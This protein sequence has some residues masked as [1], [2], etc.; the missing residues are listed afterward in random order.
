[1]VLLSPSA[2]RAGIEFSDLSLNLSERYPRAVL[3]AGGVPLVLSC[4]AQPRYLAEAVRRADGVLLTGGGDVLPSLYAPELPADLAAT[5][6]EVEPERDLAE[7]MLVREAFLQRKPLLAICRGH[8]LLNVAL[9][10]SLIVDIPRQLPQ[11]L[12]HRRVDRKNQPVHPVR[13]LPGSLIRRIFRA[14]TVE[15]NSTHHQAVDRLA[16][17]F[18]PTAVS[19]DGVIEA[20]ELAP[21][22]ADRLPWLLSVQ[23]HPERLMAEYPKFR[24]LLRAFLRACRGRRAT[25]TQPR[26]LFVIGDPSSGWERAGGRARRPRL[27]PQPSFRQTTKRTVLWLG[28]RA[29]TRAEGRKERGH[30]RPP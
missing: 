20:Y 18:R 3:G 29:D 26:A 22:C 16:P 7:L 8:Q 14:A 11:A 10:G 21:G 27:D 12:D 24:G 4:T 28:G 13:L 30:S 2:Q 5:V 9:G 23:F 19:P 6:G 1:L 15:V 17:L 25:S